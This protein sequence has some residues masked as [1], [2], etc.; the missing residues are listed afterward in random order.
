VTTLLDLPGVRRIKP[1][2]RRAQTY[3]QPRVAVLLYHRVFE[4][5]RDPQL[6]C[7]TRQRFAEHL[8]RVKS[9]YRVIH[10][11]D[12]AQGVVTGKLPRRAV[13]I[14]FDDG[15]RDN[16]LNALPVLERY[17]L[18]AT[19]FVAAGYVARNRA[20]W[21]DDLERCLLQTT[22]LPEQLEIT[23]AGRNIV[24]RLG[25]EAGPAL[26]A[27]ANG[28]DVT[29]SETP[30]ERY[31]VY[32]ELAGLLRD[33]TGTATESVL[34]VLAQWAGVPRQ[35]R[36]EYRSLCADELRGLDRS[37]L[38]E[39]G[40]HTVTHTKLSLLS[41]HEQQQEIFQSKRDLEA[42]VSHPVTSFAYPFG[43]A[44]DFTDETVRLVRNAG[45]TC[46]CAN[47]PGLSRPGTDPYRLRRFLVR[48]WDGNEFA[49][50]LESWFNG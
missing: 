14:T 3:L 48:D 5:D 12:L 27:V 25:A 36:P 41:H 24:W 26:G 18:P 2:I 37:G 17:R 35:A 11:R 38:V 30:G 22:S 46:A 28:W 29:A 4:P 33:A 31:R 47:E 6:L 9:K 20:F 1:L 15:Y 45:F 13:V 8:D 42:L 32:R 34:E 49:K 7:I 10:L 44:G 50:R 23:L 40:A 19:V 43:S 16:F 39:I 21:W